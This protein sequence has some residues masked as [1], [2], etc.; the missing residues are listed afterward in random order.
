MGPIL[1]FFG[2]QTVPTFQR[3]VGFTRCE[4]VNRDR[5][6]VCDCAPVYMTRGFVHTEHSPPPHTH[7]HTHTHT[8]HPCTYAGKK[9]CCLY[10]NHII[11][12]PTY[13]G[14]CDCLEACRCVIKALHF[15]FQGRGT[16]RR[17]EGRRPGEVCP[18][19][20]NQKK[21]SLSIESSI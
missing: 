9:C 5:A 7:T 1:H 8:L 11:C 4:T 15:L 17:D 13:G 12:P 20:P 21:R 3:V 2:L 19:H 16:H 18:P 10:S 6:V 14:L